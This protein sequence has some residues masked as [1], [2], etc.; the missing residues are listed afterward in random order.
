MFKKNYDYI[1][2]ATILICHYL[3]LSNFSNLYIYEIYDYY[4]GVNNTFHDFFWYPS[5]AFINKINVFNQFEANYPSNQPAPNYSLLHTIIFTP[6]GKLNYNFSK[7]LYLITNLILLF[8][9]YRLLRKNFFLDNKIFFLFCFF[10]FSPTLIFCLKVG[11]YS[12]FCLW[13]FL[14]FFTSNNRLFKFIGILIATLKYTF[15]PI[16]FFYLFFEKNFLTIITLIIVN[17]F[18][19]Y[20]Y[21][22]YFDV[23][24]INALINPVLTGWKTQAT[25][26]G[27]LLSL[28]G[29][30]PKFPFNIIIILSTI[31]ILHYFIHYN[32]RRCRKFDFIIVSII[33]LIS[34]RHLSYDYI[35]IMPII[36][37]LSDKIKIK[38]KI[39][40][41]IIFFY[42]LFILPWTILEPIRYTKIFIL[43]NLV[44]NLILLFIV[45]KLE[46]KNKYYKYYNLILDKYFL[47]KH[48]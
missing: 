23:S 28:L 24:F 14:I 45:L 13:G 41:L 27:D 20:F 42:F 32:L 21:S 3:Y 46:I 5:N 44:L 16:I 8:E 4:L 19:V 34:L 15:A 26:V 33:T 2:V 29:N 7:I 6:F 17:I 31:F 22:I 35:F 47:R 18:A 10:L 43:F 30:Y 1:I 37:M 36:L 12:I 11:Q 40:L 48:K 39:I 25:G 9:I 38:S